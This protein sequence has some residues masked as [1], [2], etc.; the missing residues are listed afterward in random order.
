MHRSKSDLSSVSCP[1]IPGYEYEQVQG[2]HFNTVVHLL[3]PSSLGI[4][5]SGTSLSQSGR[6]ADYQGKE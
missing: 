5:I 6:V 4:W 1:E 2:T 3:L